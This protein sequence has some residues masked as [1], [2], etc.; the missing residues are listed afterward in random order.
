MV[1]SKGHAAPAL[2][3][4]WQSGDFPGGGPAHPAPHRQL[5]AGPPQHEHG[6][7]RGYVHRQPGSGLSPACGMALAAKV[8]RKDINVY[9]LLGDGEVEEGECWEA[10]MFA[11]HYKL[12][13]LCVIMDRTACRSTAPPSEV[14]NSDPLDA[15]L[16][17]FGF[18]VPT[19]DGHDYARSKALQAFP[20]QTASPPAILDTTKGKGVSYMENQVAGT[21]R[22]PT[23]RSTP[24]MDLNAQLAELEAQVRWQSEKNRYPRQLRQRAGGTGRQITPTWW[25]WT[26]I[27]P[28]PPRPASSRQSLSRPHFRLRHCRGEH[29]GVAAGLSTMGLVPFAPALPC[30]RRPRL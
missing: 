28:P 13:N 8:Q 23:T 18:N 30:S 10:F 21:A 27:W 11:A 9:T 6:A 3:A 12:D 25:C 1:L 14:M 20:P 29:D 19:I 2:Y 22:P 5:S 17:A 26:P 15:K 4:R 16:R 7:R 24:A